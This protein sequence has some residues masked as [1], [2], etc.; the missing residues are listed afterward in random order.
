[1]V[2][3]FCHLFR[4]GVNILL[5]SSNLILDSSFDTYMPIFVSL[6]LANS[7]INSDK[8]TNKNKNP[9]VLI[10]KISYPIVKSDLLNLRNGILITEEVTNY[11]ISY[12][13]RVYLSE[14]KRNNSNS[15]RGAGLSEAVGLAHHQLVVDT[16]LPHQLGV[17]P[18]LSNHSLAE[19]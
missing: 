18:S 17:C 10:Y 19:S 13:I 5:R 11:Y 1:M 3:T 9:R 6:R 2:S 4:R 14:S 8:Q 15:H 16:F 12:T 7:S